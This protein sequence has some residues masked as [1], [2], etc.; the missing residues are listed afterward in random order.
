VNIDL[1][2]LKY[3]EDESLYATMDSSPVGKSLLGAVLRSRS[4][5]LRSRLGAGAGAGAEITNWGSGPFLFIK[6]LKK[7]YRKKSWLL[8]KFLQIITIL[9]LFGFKMHQSM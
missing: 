5:E 1:D 2:M 9:I 7:F 3:P 4:R 8:M 6:E